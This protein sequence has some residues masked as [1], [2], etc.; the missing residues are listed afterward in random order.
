VASTIED[1]ML[2]SS[3]YL[4]APTCTRFPLQSIV[5]I[6]EARARGQ[7]AVSI[8]LIKI[9]LGEFTNIVREA[10]EFAFEVARQ[11][12]IAERAQLHIEIVRMT[13]RCVV[14]EAVT[15]PVRGVCLICT[16]C[17][18]PLKITAAEEL[19]IEYI[20]VVTEKESMEC[21]EAHKEFQSRPMC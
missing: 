6:A 4:T 11:G 19:L 1:Q 8:Q 14:C 9:R 15:Q 7:N 2:R 5:E 3:N 16:H 21:K 12:T 13:L 18:F 10:L 20:E 17:G